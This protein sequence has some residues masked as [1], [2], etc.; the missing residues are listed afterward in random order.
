MDCQRAGC[1]VMSRS[2]TVWI[3]LSRLAA[4]HAALRRKSQRGKAHCHYPQQ[5]SDQGRP[6]RQRRRAGHSRRRLSTCCA[7]LKNAG[8]HVEDI[9]ADGDELVQRIIERCSNDTDTLTEEQLRLAAGHV[10]RRRLR[11]VGTPVSRNRCEAELLEAW[12]EPP[13]HVYRTGDRLAVA[14]VPMGNVFVG[15]Q[16]P[17]G[18][19]RKPHLGVPQPRPYSDPSLHRVLPLDTGRVPALTP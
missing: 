6:Y 17:R 4:R 3:Y 5:L 2:P 9:P 1:S 10:E 18:F 13:G 15:L 12:G 7:R 14:G 16:P 19:W 11:P 8:Y